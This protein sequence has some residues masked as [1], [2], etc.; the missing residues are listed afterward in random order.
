VLV[1][2]DNQIIYGARLSWSSHGVEGF[3]GWPIA[4]LGLRRLIRRPAMQRTPM[5]QRPSTEV[6]D[7]YQKVRAT[8]KERSKR[9]S[10]GGRRRSRV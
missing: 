2:N 5:A 10:G 8:Q 7:G 6:H 9:C 3:V 4:W 1:G